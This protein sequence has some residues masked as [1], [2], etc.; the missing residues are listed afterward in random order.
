MKKKTIAEKVLH[1]LI[2]S[3]FEYIPGRRNYSG[4]RSLIRFVQRI[5][6]EEKKNVKSNS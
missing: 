4:K 1:Y 3:D 5:V 2:Y 6:R